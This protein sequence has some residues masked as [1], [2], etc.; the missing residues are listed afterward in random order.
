MAT[1]GYAVDIVETKKILCNSA[2]VVIGLACGKDGLGI[3]PGKPLEK[4]TRRGEVG[5]DEL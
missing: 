4:Q 1:Q 2:G 3:V 5:R